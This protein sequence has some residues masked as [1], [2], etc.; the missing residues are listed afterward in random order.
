MNIS[1]TTGKAQLFGVAR[2][3]NAV[4]RQDLGLLGSLLA[5]LLSGSLR[6]L[7]ALLLSTMRDGRIEQIIEQ[8]TL[9]AVPKFAVLDLA[10]FT[11]ITLNKVPQQ[12]SIL[13][14]MSILGRTLIK[15]MSP[16]AR[17]V[18]FFSIHGH[19]LKISMYHLN[20]RKTK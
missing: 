19:K 9:K 17:E 20:T 10:A 14:P 2:K 11:V 6:S 5:R 15:M 7:L 12:I 13:V 3:A 4:P 18:T 1:N 8:I 16:E